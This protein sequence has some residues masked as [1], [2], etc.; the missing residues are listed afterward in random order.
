MQYNFQQISGRSPF[1]IYIRRYK[2]WVEFKCFPMKFALAIWD[3][4]DPY[5]LKFI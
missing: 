4:K 3:N 5:P 2:I 1:K